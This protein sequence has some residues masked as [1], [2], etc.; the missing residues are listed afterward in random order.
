MRG[1]RM[2]RRARRLR[3][4]RQPPFREPLEAQPESLTIIDQEFEGGA[5]SV[6][7]EKD[8]SREWIVVELV[9]AQCGEPVDTLAEVDGV[10]GEQD[11]ELWRKLDHGLGV[12]EGCAEGVELRRVSGR[13]MQC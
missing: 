4:P 1:Q 13:Q 9:A 3:P 2:Q 5:S 12:Q 10:V 11:L 6:A 7:K 8:G